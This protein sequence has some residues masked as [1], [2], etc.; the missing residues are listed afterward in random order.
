MVI[1]LDRELATCFFIGQW[2]V[3]ALVKTRPGEAVTVA[4]QK[5]VATVLTDQLVWK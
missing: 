2:P 4:G 3:V 5:C 1:E